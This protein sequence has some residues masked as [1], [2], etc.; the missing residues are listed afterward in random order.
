MI[1]ELILA[2]GNKG[3]IAEFQ[4]LLDGMGIQVQ[5][6][7]LYP[8]IGEIVEDGNTFAENALK[9]AR[10]VCQATGKPALADDSGLMV[11]ALDGA[12]GIYSAR[13]AGEAHD[14]AANNAKV[15]E[16]MKNVP[17]DKRGA[18]FFCAIALVLPD[19]REYTVEGFCRGTLLHALQGDG[20]FG[21]DPL[22]YVAELG[23]T[24]AQLTMEEKN[25]ISHRGMAN[26]KAVA[27]IQQLQQEV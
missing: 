16:L 10:T 14:D 27:I 25:A 5:S 20:G 7:K 8:E 26:K 22:F 2:S 19:G 6:M 21:Y 11:D 17:D 3:K 1:Q 13:F 15:L 4:R 9:K 24:F 23:K 12:P 18:Q